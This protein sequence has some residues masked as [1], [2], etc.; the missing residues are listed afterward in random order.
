MV[1][2]L[3]KENVTTTFATSDFALSVHQ[4]KSCR[5]LSRK[6]WKDMAAICSN[7]NSLPVSVDHICQKLSINSMAVFAKN[8]KPKSYLETQLKILVHLPWRMLGRRTSGWVCLF[9]HPSENFP[10]RVSN[11]VPSGLSA[12][13]YTQPWAAPPSS[14]IHPTILDIIHP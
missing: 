5:S 14:L 10:N 4:K 13:P 1:L 9:F 7:R 11:K 3:L 12:P 6:P 2:L 8:S